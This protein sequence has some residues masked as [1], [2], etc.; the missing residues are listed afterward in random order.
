MLHYIFTF[1][2][3]FLT[4]SLLHAQDSVESSLGGFQDTSQSISPKDQWL[5]EESLSESILKNMFIDECNRQGDM[6]IYCMCTY[7]NIITEFGSL[8]DMPEQFIESSDFQT[9]I[10]FPCME[11]IDITQTG[12]E[13]S[14][15]GKLHNEE[16][17]I[18]DAYMMSCDPDGYLTDFCDCTYQNL[19]SRFGPMLDSPDGYIESEAFQQ[20]IVMPCIDYFPVD[21]GVDY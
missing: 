6:L 21:Q 20:E 2:I 1:T 15:G 10:T 7:N 11:Y 17:I 8:L 13:K 3:L 4:G 5:E 12:R 18:R 14:T 16:E 19:S 9:L